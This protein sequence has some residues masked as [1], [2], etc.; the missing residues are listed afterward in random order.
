M[1]GNQDNT[2][3]RFMQEF[4]PYREFKKIG[5]FTKDM[6]GDYEAQA[7]R[8]CDFFG[9]KTV[10]E[11]RSKEIRCHLTYGSHKT[12]LGTDRPLNIDKQG[13][14]KEEPFITI[15]PGIYDSDN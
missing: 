3:K 7:K 11:Y 13:K 14:L 4:F 9:L 2:L 6:K 8:V 12:G 15:I 5:F 10:Y 1:K